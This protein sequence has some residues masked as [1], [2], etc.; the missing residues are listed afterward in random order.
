GMNIISTNIYFIG[1]VFITRYLFIGSNIISGIGIRALS[2]IIIEDIR[3]K[4]IRDKGIR[5]KGIKSKGIRGKEIGGK[6]FSEFNNSYN[7]IYGLV[8]LVLISNSGLVISILL[9]KSCI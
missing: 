2:P 8:A 5:G 9:K 6:G 7:A 1:N 3:G 4:G